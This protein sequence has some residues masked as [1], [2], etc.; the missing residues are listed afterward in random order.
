MPFVED[1]VARLAREMIEQHGRRAGHAAAE[2]VNQMIDDG[3]W[4]GRDLWARVVHSI[5][6][7]QGEGAPHPAADAPAV[8]QAPRAGLRR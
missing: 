3:D 4:A 1:E 2:R 8:R 7:Q 5:H 6:E